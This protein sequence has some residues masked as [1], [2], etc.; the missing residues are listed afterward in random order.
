MK[1]EF[2]EIG[3][4]VENESETWEEGVT[5]EEPSFFIIGDLKHKFN[6]LLKRYK[7]LRFMKSHCPAHSASILL[8]LKEG[9]MFRN[10]VYRK[11]R[12]NDWGS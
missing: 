3:L 11:Q 9:R 2:K 6:R 10:V 8:G 12:E 5:S 7:E 1:E 4:L